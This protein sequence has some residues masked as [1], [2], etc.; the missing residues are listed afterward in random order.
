MSSMSTNVQ[1]AVIALLVVNILLTV[2]YKYKENYDECVRVDYDLTI[3]KLNHSDHSEHS[4]QSES[5]TF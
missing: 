2:Y 3:K 5:E 1:I 4:D